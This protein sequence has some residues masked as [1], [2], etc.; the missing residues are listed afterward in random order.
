ML[1][2]NRNTLPVISV[3]AK[4]MEPKTSN[5]YTT[6]MD[7]DGYG[8]VMVGPG[9]IVYNLSV[10]DNC[11]N[12]YGNMIEP[13]VSLDGSE[14]CRA[15]ACCGNDI[16]ITSGP[17]A[18]E[19]GFVTGKLQVNNTLTAWFPY[20]TLEKMT[21]SETFLIK[22]YGCGL[23]LSDW[24]DIDIY[25]ISP[26]L[27]DKLGLKEENGEIAVPVTHVIPSFLMGEGWGTLPFMDDSDILT[28]DPALNEQY[29]LSSL[30]FGDVVFISDMDS[31]NGK[32][33]RN[34]AGTVGIVV[35]SDGIGNGE[36]PGVMTVLSSK[37]PLL[38][39]VIDPNANIALYLGIRE[40][41]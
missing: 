6:W 23:R 21:A 25:S 32:A 16:I 39:P 9:G 10:G 37:K 7:R 15:Y 4:V 19:K 27:F 2:T 29:G 3:T 5:F 24:P 38:R 41:L 28:D 8:K 13:G 17:A 22:A 35:C 14:A 18:G 36:G 12:V 31:T 26:D 40:V 34:G 33:Y 1:L 11:M 30:R 20:K